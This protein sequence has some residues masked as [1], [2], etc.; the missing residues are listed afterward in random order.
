[1]CFAMAG[2]ACFLANV[3]NGVV[4]I[5]VAVNG[6][7]FLFGCRTI[8]SEK[9]KRNQEC[10]DANFFHL[11]FLPKLNIKLKLQMHSLVCLR[12][13]AKVCFLKQQNRWLI[14]AFALSNECFYSVCAGNIA[15]HPYRN[16]SNL[17]FSIFGQNNDSNVGC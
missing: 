11:R 15:K 14:V 5:E 4:Q 3:L 12:Y 17:E 10:Y 7:N 9:G 2:E 6:S 16:S 1:M 8:E 13:Y